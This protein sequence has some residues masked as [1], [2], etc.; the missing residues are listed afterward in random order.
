MRRRVF[1]SGAVLLVALITAAAV[2]AA[3]GRVTGD[4][5]G[6]RVIVPGAQAS[7]TGSA[8]S[9]SYAYRDLVSMSAY[10]TGLEQTADR[11]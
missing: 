3:G 4:A 10:T 9:G 2:P 8:A 6:V 1:G 7:G 5:Y 11:A